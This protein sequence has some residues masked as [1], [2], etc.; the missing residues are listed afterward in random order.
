MDSQSAT[1]CL[2]VVI[3]LEQSCLVKQNS[4]LRNQLESAYLRQRF[5]PKVC[6]VDARV[7]ARNIWE[8]EKSI[9]GVEV[10]SSSCYCWAQA[11]LTVQGHWEGKRKNKISCLW[12]ESIAVY[13]LVT[14]QATGNTCRAPGIGCKVLSHSYL[15]HETKLKLRKEPFF[16]PPLPSV[17]NPAASSFLHCKTSSS[18]IYKGLPAHPALGNEHQKAHALPAVGQNVTY[19]MQSLGQHFTLRD[20]TSRGK[21]T[22]GLSSQQRNCR[23]RRQA[24]AWERSLWKRWQDWLP[25]HC[26][27]VPL[28]L[29]CS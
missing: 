16:L 27:K 12:Q 21:L 22:I 4:R 5:W 9:C 6:S 13:Q 25:Q 23:A 20:G 29:D 26:V 28:G 8:P 18:V 1:I 10:S 19:P 11:V 14:Q 17:K 7:E 24:W 15:L 3:Y 2:I